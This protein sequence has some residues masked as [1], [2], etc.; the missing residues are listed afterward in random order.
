MEWILIIFIYAGMFSKGDNVAITNVPGFATE[1]ECINAGKK[2]KTLVSG[3]YKDAKFV[4]VPC[5]KK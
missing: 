4:C 1:Q 5:T 2:A 3:T